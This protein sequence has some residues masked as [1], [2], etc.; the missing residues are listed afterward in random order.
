MTSGNDE[1]LPASVA[2]RLSSGGMPS[3]GAVVRSAYGRDQRSFH[4]RIV[5]GLNSAMMK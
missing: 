2:G 3:G 5:S 4:R 1:S